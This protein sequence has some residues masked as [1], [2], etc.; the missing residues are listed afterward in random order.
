MEL[1]IAP[2]TQ[3][4]A[5]QA[6]DFLVAHIN[7]TLKTNG[8]YTIA[9]SGGSTPKALHEL[10]ASEP[11]KSH[12]DWGKLHF[13]WGDERFVPFNDDK[14][15]AK[16]AFDTLLD[17][18]PVNKDYI[19][20]MQTEN[21]TPEDSAA[22]YERVLHEYFPLV[23]T[24][25]P[26][27]HPDNTPFTTFDLCILGMGDDGHTLSL[28]P[29]KPIIHET[30]KW[31]DAFWLDEQDMYRVTITHPVANHSAVVMFLV[32]GAGKAPALK[33]VLEGEYNPDKYPSQIIKPKGEL[34]W[35]LD[36]AAAKDLK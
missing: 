29:G 24:H 21:I 34:H 11:Y 8:K 14:N 33:E 10:L 22:A 1:H 6:A 7:E 13:F 20:V 23:H 9:L 30:E 32:A 25:H 4:L 2:N 31:A 36:E 28:F 12:I 16:M 5:K 18:V 35:F 27:D 15:N 19:H 26:D 17:K 3:Q